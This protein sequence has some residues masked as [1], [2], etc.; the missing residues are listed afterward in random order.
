MFK[1]RPLTK[2]DYVILSVLI[3]TAIILNF[4]L[5]TSQSGVCETST[6]LACIPSFNF[7]AIQIFAYLMISIAILHSLYLYYIFGDKDESN[8][9]DDINPIAE[10]QPICYLEPLVLPGIFSRPK[11]AEFSDVENGYYVEVDKAYH[12]SNR[13]IEVTSNILPKYETTGDFY[14]QVSKSERDLFLIQEN[15]CRYTLYTPGSYQEEGYYVEV[16]TSCKSTEYYIHNQKRMPPTAEEG[17]RWCR[18]T[19]RYLG[20]DR[21]QLNQIVQAKEPVIELFRQDDYYLENITQRQ[22][23]TS[24]EEVENGFYLEIGADYSTSNRVVE[25]VNDVLPRLINKED[26]FIKITEEEK[27]TFTLLGVDFSEFIK[28]TPGSYREPGYYLEVDLDNKSTE[29]YIF[30]MKRLPPTHKKGYRW[31]RVTKRG[32]KEL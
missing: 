27:S 21:N 30:T 9:F 25:V 28:H 12:T 11:L 23:F 29:Y 14:I 10:A 2:I 18:I 22:Q 16:D 1:Q 3:I 26:V 4:L 19:G 8:T 5:W 6:S 15:M 20:E 17:Y 7:R 31:V 32:V 13:V 24:N